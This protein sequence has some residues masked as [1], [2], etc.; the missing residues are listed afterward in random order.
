MN[1]QE[2]IEL[3][4]SRIPIDR[5]QIAQL[6]QI[7]IAKIEQGVLFVF[8]T[9]SGSCIVSFKLLLDAL[10]Q[11]PHAI[12]PIYVVDTDTLDHEAFMLRFGKR[13]NGNG[14]T[15]WIKNGKVLHVDIGYADKENQVL[16]DRS[17][18][19]GRISSLVSRE[20]NTGNV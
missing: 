17:V 7:D 16:L 15:I 1:F 9:W 12:F 19:Q 3:Y 4:C 11:C 14:E 13:L 6:G 20:G 2:Q 5:I 18:L 8:A 10:A